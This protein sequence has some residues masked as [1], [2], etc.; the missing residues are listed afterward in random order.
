MIR[1]D[2]NR[3]YYFNSHPHEE[4]DLISPSNY[5]IPIYFNSHPHEEDDTVLHLLQS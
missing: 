1:K 4:D 2:G 5:S 3:Q